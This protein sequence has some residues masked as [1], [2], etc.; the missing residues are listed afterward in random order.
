MSGQQLPEDPSQ[1]GAGEQTPAVREDAEAA[2]SGSSFP[3]DDDDAEERGDQPMPLLEHLGELRARLFRCLI[4][5][6]IGFAA[7]YSG[8]DLLY[9]EILRPVEGFLPEGARVV[10]TTLPGPFFLH[11]KIAA[12]AS[13]FVVSPYLFYQVWAFVAPGLYAHERKYIVPIALLSAVFFVGGA[14]FCYLV[15][16]PFAFPFFLSYSTDTV[17]A[18][19]DVVEYFS[20]VLK[21]ILAFGLI[22]EMPLFSLFLARLGLVTAKLM[23]RTRKYAILGIFIVAAILT[24]PDVFSQLLMAGPMLVLY[25]LSILVAAVFGRKPASPEPAAEADGANSETSGEQ[26]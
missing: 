10:F 25:E 22:F 2:S 17:T 7:C 12:L 18:M 14:A 13:L 20:F 21:L 3:W 8:A 11:L 15:V 23:R 6:F 16:L 9:N 1:T 5:L 4:A 24:P 19:L 26:P